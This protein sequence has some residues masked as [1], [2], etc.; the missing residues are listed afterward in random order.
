MIGFGL[1]TMPHVYTLE[2]SIL[3]ALTFLPFYICKQKQVSIIP[4][5][6]RESSFIF[7]VPNLV[8]KKSLW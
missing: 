5:Q 3:K 6:G 8:P 1:H 2:Q 7:K 4:T